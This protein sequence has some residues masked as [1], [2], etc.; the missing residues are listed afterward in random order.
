MSEE[1]SLDDHGQF[2]ADE[3]F[4]QNEE[5]SSG[6]ISEESAPYI[7]INNLDDKKDIIF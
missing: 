4:N 5:S 2:V 3:K 7:E 6:E 1:S